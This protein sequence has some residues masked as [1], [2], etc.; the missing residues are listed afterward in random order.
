M[1]IYTFGTVLKTVRGT[2]TGKKG[3]PLADAEI[4]LIDFELGEIE[5]VY[6]DVNGDYSFL[7]EPERNFELKG[8]K[9][10][11]FGDANSLDTKSEDDIIISNL[12]LEKDPGISLFIEVF[13]SE[14][15]L[16]LDSVMVTILDNMIDKTDS[17]LTDAT[18]SFIK[19]LANK[20]LQ[21]RGSFNIRL[22]KQGYLVITE[23]Y[24]V[25]FDKEGQYNVLEDLH[26]KLEKIEVGLDLTNV[27]DVKPIYFDLGKYKIRDDA[28]L[29]LD[30]IVQVMNDNPK[31]V[32][33]LGSHTDSRG[34]A[35]SN[36]SLSDKRAKASADYIKT[37][38]TNPERISGKG[39]G[40]E[41]LVN[42]C[43]DD[44]QCTAEQHQENRRTEFIIIEM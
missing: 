11:Y 9:D 18:G 13:D 23:T 38:I 43:A 8:V 26:I 40:E 12:S 14:T 41:K 2:A 10:G 15:N 36:Q 5:T 1:D 34:S 31:M 42:D 20:K 29:E 28:A 19:P 22:E 3:N 7:A 39:Y 25:L 16:P 32:I 44:V 33:E 21:E 37:R 30:K 27:I 4:K 35:K 6:S 17:T 24:N